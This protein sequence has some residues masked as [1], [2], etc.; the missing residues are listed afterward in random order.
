MLF[1]FFLTFSCLTSQIGTGTRRGPAEGHVKGHTFDHHMFLSIS[2]AKSL[3]QVHQCF[4]VGIYWELCVFL[5]PSGPSCTV[6]W[7]HKGHSS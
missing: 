1:P 5:C 4:V 7:A 6:T 2:A 3:Q